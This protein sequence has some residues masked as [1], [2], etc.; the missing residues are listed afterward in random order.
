M[1]QRLK[2]KL[3]AFLKG[4]AV[5]LGI[6]NI[7]K[8]DDGIGP[9]LIKRL[10]GRVDYKLIDCG[11]TPENY[12]GPIQKENP[13]TLILIDCADFGA[14]PGEIG[15]FEKDRIKEVGLTTHDASCKLLMEVLS[16][17][18]PSI[19]MIAIQPGSTQFG[20]SLSAEAEEAL[21]KLEEI[22]TQ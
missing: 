14:A 21:R 15:I 10:S 4:K 6:G 12:V 5:L 17:T 11:T 20:E 22:L 2:E 3:K 8:G 18:I 9:E 1:D 7:L 19:F 16:E 13:D